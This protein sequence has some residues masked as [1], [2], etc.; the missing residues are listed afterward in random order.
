MEASLFSIG[1]TVQIIELHAE[2]YNGELAE[3]RGP[4]LSDTKR[5]PVQLYTGDKDKLAIK[6]M[7]LKRVMPISYKASYS[8]GVYGS[9]RI[10][11]DNEDEYDE[12]M[13]QQFDQYDANHDRIVNRKEFD[14]MVS[15]E[16]G[17]SEKAIADQLFIKLD[18]NGDGLISRAEAK[19]A[20]KLA[21]TDGDNEISLEEF[22]HWGCIPSPKDG[23][24]RT[25]AFDVDKDRTK[26][27]D[28][29][30]TP[31]ISIYNQGD[32]NTCGPTSAAYMF[33]YMQYK[34]DKAKQVLVPSRLFVYYN[35]RE[36]GSKTVEMIMVEYDTGCQLRDVFES[37]QQK[38]TC[39][40]NEW[41]YDMKKCGIKPNKTCYANA[42]N[43]V[44]IGY[45]RVAQKEEQLKAAL[46][47]G[48][49]ILLGF[50]V[51]RPFLTIGEKDNYTYPPPSDDGKVVGGHAVVIVGYD[52]EKKVF[53]IRNS[54]GTEWGNNGYCYFTFDFVLS[55]KCFDFW[56]MEGVEMKN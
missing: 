29:S 52:D 48:Y 11:G 49:P 5:W 39:T 17:V 10:Y 42:L 45:A 36:I 37:I 12:K 20:W 33:Q 1:E 47:S 4:Y 7:N 31:L 8:C 54:H 38:G 44:V 14:Q 35:A 43:N 2:Q 15:Q 28:L 19:V 41:K 56:I 50:Y 9:Y 3:I 24:D 25:K 16:F 22:N 32:T 23:R 6:S 13:K 30:Q 55:D 34:Q 26:A 51:T 21:N 40:E 46:Y 53:K 18:L 27:L